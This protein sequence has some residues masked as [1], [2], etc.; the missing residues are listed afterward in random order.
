[1][2]MTAVSA[3]T[4]PM[5]PVHSSRPSTPYVARVASP[6]QPEAIRPVRAAREASRVCSRSPVYAIMRKC[7]SRNGPDVVDPYFGRGLGVD[8]QSAEVLAG[9]RVLD[10]GVE[11]GVAAT[12]DVKALQAL[13]SVITARR[14]SRA[15]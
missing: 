10:P 4:R 11:G 1:M 5:A 2:T 12:G 6:V 7:L 14:G 13:G 3:T 15:G 8:E 9:L